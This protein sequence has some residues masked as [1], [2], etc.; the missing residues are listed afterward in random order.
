MGISYVDGP[1]L[2]RSLHAASDWVAAGREEINRINV[3]PVPD[4]DTGT[5]FSLT[6]RAVADALRALGDASLSETARTASRAA[7]LGA[8]GNSGMMLAHFL[9]GFS[10]GLGEALQANVTGIARAIS[11]GSER[12]DQALDDPR[13]GTI[14]TVAREAAAAAERAALQTDDIAEFMHLML[15]EGERALART[16]ELMA[17]LKEAGV[18]DAG[19]KGFVRMLEG[20]VRFIEG[21]PI[22]PA[23]ALPLPAES[24]MV[25]AALA[26]VAAERDFRYCTEVLVRGESLPPSN[27][28]RAAMHDFGG[29]V[30]VALA[31]DI[32]KIHVHTDTPDAVFSYAT[33]WGRV[34]TTKAEDMR[35][36]H[37]HLT[38]DDR[39]QVAVIADSSA[40]LP[41]A[42]LDR[43]RIT[44]VPLQVMF[45]PETFRDRVELRPEEFYRRLRTSKELPTT[46]QPTPGE[47]IRVFRDARQ[48]AHEIVAV[49]LSSGLSGTFQSAVAAR[50]ASSLDGIHLVDSRS[51]SLGLGLLALRGAELAEAGWT[52]Q[53]IERELERIRNR[54]GMLLTVD[55]YDN[56]IR[57]GRVSRGKAWIGGMLD[58]KPILTLDDEG[59]VIPLD[60]V[61][62]R[63]NLIPRVLSHLE[64]RLTPRPRRVRFGIGHADAPEAAERLRN[65]IVAA[66]RPEDCFVTLATGVLGTHVGPGAWAVFYQ[67]EDDEATA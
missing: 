39:R 9:L 26:E 43:H 57:S 22:L 49:L 42:V 18:V 56:L 62:G 53:A 48:E 1:R 30:V 67:V 17:V 33:R 25:P 55:R 44:L 14:L 32:L 35:A 8:R 16:P 34:A 36:Q 37:A 4:G 5:N 20:V 45:G 61:R 64:Q 66:F 54:S 12:L 24:D 51:A 47:F 63:E 40:D 52:G 50:K 31:G 23:A 11:A 28:V 60:R 19:G 13:E 21:D 65:A 59:R 10:D 6:L 3:F 2:A 15:A 46:S 27:E 29:S 41:D 7:V 38:H 58:V